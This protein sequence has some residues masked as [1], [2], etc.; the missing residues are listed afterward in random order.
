M[1]VDS[2]GNECCGYVGRVKGE[3][4]GAGLKEMGEH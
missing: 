4:L 2:C 3:K 1:V